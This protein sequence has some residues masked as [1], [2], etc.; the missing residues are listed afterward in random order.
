LN[1][2]KQFLSDRGAT[3]HISAP[4]TPQQNPVSK[5][6]NRTTTKKAQALLKQANISHS[7]WGY[8]VKTAVFLENITPTRKNDWVLSYEIWFKHLFKLSC[9]RP[10]GCRAF[11]N[12]IK[13]NR[14]SKF[15]ETSKKGIMVGYH[16]GMHNWCILMEEG[17]VELS[18]DITFYKALYPGISTSCPAGFGDPPAL[19][20]Y[21]NDKVPAE[22]AP[23]DNEQ[24]SS[25]TLTT[26]GSSDLSSSS[27]NNNSK[28]QLAAE[29]N[30]SLSAIPPRPCPGF[31]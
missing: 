27:S 28:Y 20:E 23:L 22:S 11:V 8:A 10:F 21:F 2:F 12:V 31:D 17:R 3:V 5:C 9:L 26:S 7:F 13:T 19:G 24:D 18:H 30:P 25:P 1:E 15:S 4:Y 29:L 14:N 16:L 6:G